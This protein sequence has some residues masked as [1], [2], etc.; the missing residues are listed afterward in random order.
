VF[1]AFYH[2]H[3]ALHQEDLPFWLELSRQLDG[4]VLELG[5]GTGRVLGTLAQAG[6]TVVGLDMDAGMLAFLRAQLRKPGFQVSVFQADMAYFALACRF[7]L[8]MLPCNTLTTLGHTLR[9]QLFKR[10]REHLNQNGLFAASLPNPLYLSR[11]P[12]DGPSEVE[13]VFPHPL[14]GNPV[15]VSSA[16]QRGKETFV[17]TWHYDHLLPDG[18]IER[19]SVATRHSMQPLEAYASELVQAGLSL[20]SVWGDFDLSAYEADSP[21]LIFT[22]GR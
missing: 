5:C 22:A 20:R 6:R 15:Q 9:Q 2:A 1:P 12:R 11:L 21:Y 8:I 7:A 13:E 10:V 17:L 14:T 16:W 4:P 3:H 19:L 18:Q